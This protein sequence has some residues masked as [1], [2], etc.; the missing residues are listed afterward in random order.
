MLAKERYRILC[1]EDPNRPIFVQAWWLDATCG[2]SWNVCLVEKSGEV[3]AAMP[4]FVKKRSGFTLLTQ[5]PLTQCLGPWLKPS[6]AK[7]SKR[8]GAEKDLLAA[9]IQQLP[10]HDYFRQNWHHSHSNWLPFY[11]QGF[12]QTT[13][14]TYRLPKVLD[15]NG[16]WD[17]FRENIRRDIR[18]A[19]NRYKLSIRT[20]VSL[21]NFLV[22]NEKV[23]RRQGIHLPYSR[24]MVRRIDEACAGKRRRRIFLAEDARGNQHAAV[25]IVWDNQS[26]YYLM[27][28][29][30]PDLRSSGATSLC[31]W[32]AIKFAATVCESFDFEGSMIEPVERFFRA[33]GA[34]QTPYFCVQ[35]T[36]SFILRLRDGAFKLVDRSG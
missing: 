34:E 29:G 28:G 18:K 19:Q 17:G 31:M 11:W 4:Y 15:V 22:L 26:A 12:S 30:D 13:R 5:P 14:Y 36:N 21:E 23:F 2:D 3:L 10:P 24:S 20:D 1:E 27:G 8:L 16:V 32:E 7:Y 9:L 6:E 25:Y 33:F 35:K